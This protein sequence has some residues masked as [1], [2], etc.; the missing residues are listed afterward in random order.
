MKFFILFQY[1]MYDGLY[2]RLL[3]CPGTYPLC[4]T[5]A[6]DLIAP[7]LMPQTTSYGQAI[8]IVL[9][10]LG[11]HLHSIR[12]AWTHSSAYLRPLSSIIPLL[13]QA[14]D[15]VLMTTIII[16]VTKRTEHLHCEKEF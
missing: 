9:D 4:V 6:E 15:L 16:V 11:D 13:D 1:H 2:L 10:D 7:I 14:S 5:M 8:F 3:G 12:C